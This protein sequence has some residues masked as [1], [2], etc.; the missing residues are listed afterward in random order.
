MEEA[1]EIDDVTF[2]SSVTKTEN[3]PDSDK[4]DTKVSEIISNYIE[5]I[6]S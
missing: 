2:V 4:D 6:I 3:T 1:T 5:L